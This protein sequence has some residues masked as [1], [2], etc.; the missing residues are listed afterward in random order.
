[1]SFPASDGLFAHCN[2]GVDEVDH[3]PDLHIRCPYASSLVGQ[4]HPS[5]VHFLI[6]EFCHVECSD[7]SL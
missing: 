4:W 2:L 1:M 5:I 7:H 3:D 6:L